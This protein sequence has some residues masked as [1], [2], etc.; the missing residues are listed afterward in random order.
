VSV[1]GPET[2]GSP[3]RPGPKP[4]AGDDESTPAVTVPVTIGG[5]PKVGKRLTVKPGSGWAGEAPHRFRYQWQ[6]CS[7]VKG[8]LRCGNLKGKTAR[9]LVV[10][11]SYVGKRLRV[12]TTARSADGRTQR[13]TSRTTGAV[14]R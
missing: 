9:T 2:P 4:P 12:L 13:R 6:S 3:A 11:R 10:S 1:D 7:T 5:M 14:R 8:K